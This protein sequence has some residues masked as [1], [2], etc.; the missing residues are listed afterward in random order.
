M[1]ALQISNIHIANSQR[2]SIL[3]EIIIVFK[4]NVT[5]ISSKY[6]VFHHIYKELVYFDQFERLLIRDFD[7]FL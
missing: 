4:Y 6:M 1:E 5:T 2:N 7:Q 3:G